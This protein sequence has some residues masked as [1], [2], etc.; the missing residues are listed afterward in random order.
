MKAYMRNIYKI[1]MGVG[2]TQY[3][4]ERASKNGQFCSQPAGL[5]PFP[6]A[7]L[8]TFRLCFPKCGPL[9]PAPGLSEVLIKQI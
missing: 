2:P 5:M 8:T 4:K 3:V 7:G 1:V 9:P 6:H